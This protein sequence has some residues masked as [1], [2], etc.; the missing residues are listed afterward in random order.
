[1]LPSFLQKLVPAKN[2]SFDFEI[3]LLNSFATDNIAKKPLEISDGRAFSEIYLTN[4]R[5]TLIG[6]NR[7]T[8]ELIKVELCKNPRKNLDIENEFALLRRLNVKGAMSCPTAIELGILDR[9]D[10]GEVVGDEYL[11]KA[12]NRQSFTYMLQEYV[13]SSE[14]AHI[15]DL[16][17]AMLEQKSLGVYQGDVKPANICF[18]E[19]KGICILVDYDQSEELPEVVMK[20]NTA[21]YLQWCDAREKRKYPGMFDT[22]RR[23]FA[24]LDHQRHIK[25]MLRDGAFNLALI[26]PYRRQITTNTEDGVYHTIASDLVY[27]DGIRD[28]KQRTALLD[29]V[30]F[31]LGERVLDV[32]CNAGLLCHY[33]DGRGCRP[34][35]IDMDAHIV[36]SARMIANI[37]GVDATFL[38]LDI[39]AKDLPGEF[40]TICLFSVIHHTR[41]L[42]ENG[43][44]IAQR[45]KRIL[46]ECRPVEHGRKPVRDQFGQIDWVTASVWNYQ[47]EAELVEGMQELFPGFVVERK[48]GYADKN[49]ILFEMVKK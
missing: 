45:C 14:K 38:E 28:I 15:S 48:V 4:R 30:D 24:G 23:H 39:D 33:L 36:V 20:M 2:R 31:V 3:D 12:K 35:G 25:P 11:A 13:E 27:A 49:R 44:K 21:D 47:D 32:G 17:F 40:D 46:I 42:K 6:I 18:D 16:I 43:E 8:K 41:N 37:L 10:L 7:E 19:Q 5:E 9:H 26:T 34:T 1:M 22:W 29:D